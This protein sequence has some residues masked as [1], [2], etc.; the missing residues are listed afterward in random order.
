[1]P[2]GRLTPEVEEAMA[3]ELGADSLNYLRIEDLAECVDKPAETLCQACVD[4]RYPTLAGTKL[5]QLAIENDRR[6]T[7]ESAGLERTYDV[8]AV[9][10][11][12]AATCD[13]R[14]S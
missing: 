11:P 12:A 6:G 1:M 7:G 13:S 2:D 4:G 10:R 8:S 9:V 3:R 5:Y 14:N